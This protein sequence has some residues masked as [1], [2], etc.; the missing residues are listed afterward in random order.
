MLSALPSQSRSNKNFWSDTSH[1]SVSRFIT[2]GS[3]HLFAP[4]FITSF[5]AISNLLDIVMLTLKLI[6]LPSAVT[7]VPFVSKLVVSLSE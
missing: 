1:T 2:R 4:K 5:V 3:V 7:T 6:S